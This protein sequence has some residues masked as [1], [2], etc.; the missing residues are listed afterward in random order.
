MNGKRAAR[1]AYKCVLDPKTEAGSDGSK[2]P[3]LLRKA[4]HIFRES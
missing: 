1:V 3:N 2:H 4:G